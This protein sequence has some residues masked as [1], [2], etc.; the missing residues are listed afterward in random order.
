MSVLFQYGIPPTFWTPCSALSAL[1]SHTFFW[2]CSGK[3]GWLPNNSPDIFEI[4]TPHILICGGLLW[5][6]K[7]NKA[8]LASY[9]FWRLSLL[10][11]S[12]WELSSGV[13]YGCFRPYGFPLW[14]CSLCFLLSWLAV[15]LK[16]GNGN[17][18]FVSIKNRIWTTKNIVA[19]RCF[20]LPKT[21]NSIH[22]HRL[23]QTPYVILW[24]I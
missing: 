12:C 16:R 6:I 3:T 5:I 19:I 20:L 9:P 17:F 14:L 2:Y 7:Q 1:Q 23:V 21:H 13:G 11:L 22:N 10:Y 8:G 15:G 18:L 4:V 24:K